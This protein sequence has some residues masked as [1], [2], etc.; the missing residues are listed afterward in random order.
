ML[1][2]RT[3]LARHFTLL[4]RLL[5]AYCTLHLLRYRPLSH[6]DV[7]YTTPQKLLQH[8]THFITLCR[9]GLFCCR[10]R[11]VLDVMWMHIRVCATDLMLPS[12]PTVVV[13]RHTVELKP[14]TT[15]LLCNKLTLPPLKPCVATQTLPSYTEPS[16]KYINSLLQPSSLDHPYPL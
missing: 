5:H 16:L 7:I 15:N 1:Q 13:L 3:P 12:D 11:P 4:T 2:R 14:Q 10:F 9:F 8:F 6:T